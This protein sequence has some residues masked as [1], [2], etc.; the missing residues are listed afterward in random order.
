ML[1][2]ALVLRVQWPRRGGRPAV[3]AL[4]ICFFG[5]FF[6]LYKVAGSYTTAARASLALSTLPPQTMMVAALLSVEPLTA[7]KSVGVGVAVLGVIAALASG[8]SSAPPGAWRTDHDG[9]GS[10]HGFL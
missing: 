2:A 7:R 8:L 6:V 4:G 3:A 1:P 9:R 10:V 5:L